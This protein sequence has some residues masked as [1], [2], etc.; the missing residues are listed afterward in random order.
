MPNG[1]R[2]PCTT[3]TGTRT[4]A[5][6]HRPPARG[7]PAPAH[8]ASL[9]LRPLGL[10]SLLRGLVVGERLR[11]VDVTER[12]MPRH[13]PLGGLDAVLLREHGAERLH[14]HLAEARQRL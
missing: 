13:E 4:P 5:R 12:R 10:V 11:G 7:A 6:A 2:S 8:A 9:P 3:S 14:L 1:S